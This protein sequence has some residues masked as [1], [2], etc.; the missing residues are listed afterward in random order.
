[1]H[2]LTTAYSLPINMMP[3]TDEERT[4]F[5]TYKN[6][7]TRITDSYKIGD[8]QIPLKD[9]FYIYGLIAWGGRSGQ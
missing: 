8:Q 9:W 6:A 3:R 2:L 4:V 5:N 7:F 1:M